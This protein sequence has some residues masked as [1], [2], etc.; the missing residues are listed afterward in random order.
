MAADFTKNNLIVKVTLTYLSALTVLCTMLVLLYCVPQLVVSGVI[1]PGPLF[2]LMVVFPTVVGVIASL[3][4]AVTGAIALPRVLRAGQYASA[5]MTAGQIITWTI[6]F[7][8]VLWAGYFATTGWEL[9]ML[10]LALFIGQVVVA[11][12]LVAR[13]RQTRRAA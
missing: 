7:A 9:L 10:P 4:G 6:A 1:E 8:I 12:G 13:F 11:G 3:I 5:A 2:E